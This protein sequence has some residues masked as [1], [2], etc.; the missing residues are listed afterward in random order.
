MAFKTVFA[1]R[2]ILKG[3][4]K[5]KAAAA[6]STESVTID[7]PCEG[8]VVQPGH[9]AVRISGAPESDIELSVN[10]SDWMVCRSAVGYHWFDW[11]PAQ[12]GKNSLVVRQKNGDGKWKKTKKRLV[13][14]SSN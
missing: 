2:K 10:D 3:A 11:F 6:P 7:Y 8:E 13:V 5:K 1:K 12:P 14:C 4:P 9:Y